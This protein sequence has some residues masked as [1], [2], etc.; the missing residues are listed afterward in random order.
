MDLRNAYRQGAEKLLTDEGKTD[1]AA[2]I[3][4]LFTTNAGHDKITIG[5]TEF[6]I[7]LAV[8]RA[9]DAK[10]AITHPNDPRSEVEDAMYLTLVVR[11]R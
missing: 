10:N 7:N 2:Q 11:S 8:V 4:H 1:L 9:D 5:M 3:S 6:Q